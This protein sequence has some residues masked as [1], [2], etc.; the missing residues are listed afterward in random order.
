MDR[1]FSVHVR[2]QLALGAVVAGLTY[3]GL[4]ALGRLG[5]ADLRYE[6]S[7]AIIA[8][9]MQLIPIVGPMLSTIPAMLLALTISPQASL[10]VLGLYVAIQFATAA[11][12]VPLIEGRYVDIHPALFVV[13][14]VLLSQFGFIWVVVAAPLSI[15]LRDLLRYAYG[16]FSEPPRPA[17]LLP[18]APVPLA[19]TIHRTSRDVR[20][21]GRSSQHVTAA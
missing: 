1:V 20:S 18:G 14:L 4:L 13:V 9:V 15:V 12:V 3:V 5:V 10:A 7:L 11:L 8:G 21:R 17:G 19:S 16:R 6:L 2:G